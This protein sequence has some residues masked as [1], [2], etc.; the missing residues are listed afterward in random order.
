MPSQLRMLNCWQ[1]LLKPVQRII[2][3]SLTLPWYGSTLLV[4]SWN[5]W[6]HSTHQWIL[7]AQRF[8]L[9]LTYWIWTFWFHAV[10]LLTL[11]TSFISIVT[12]K[13][14][15]PLGLEINERTWYRELLVQLIT[16]LSTVL[17]KL[18]SESGLSMNM[19]ETESISDMH[20]VHIHVHHNIVGYCVCVYI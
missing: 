20:T 15:L 11:Y 9:T 13:I 17:W 8:N 16:N 1:N 19:R 14:F 18:N 12:L 5:R 7:V 4:S 2:N 6:T 3:F 10:S